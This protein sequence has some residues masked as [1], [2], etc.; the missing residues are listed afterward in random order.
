MKQFDPRSYKGRYKLARPA[1]TTV[2][3]P[4][5]EKLGLTWLEYG[6]FDSIHHLSHSQQDFPYCTMSKKEL[7]KFLGISERFVYKTIKKGEAKRI[8]EKNERGDLRTTSCWTNLV[9]LY[10]PKNKTH[11]P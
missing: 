4:V 9:Y 5:R 6:V 7:A 2:I 8:I 11:H 1:F 10:S 3:H